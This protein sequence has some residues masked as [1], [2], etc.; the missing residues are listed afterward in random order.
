M[1]S[2]QVVRDHHPLKG[3]S[4]QVLGQMHCRGRLELL[5]VLPDGSKSLIPAA[6]TDHAPAE[7]EGTGAGPAPSGA[8]V[9]AWPGDL[10]EASVLVSAL[11][12]RTISDPEQA[13]RQFPSKEDHRA[14]RPAQSATRAVTPAAEPADSPA[15]APGTAGGPGPARPSHRQDDHRAPRG[16]R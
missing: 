1:T 11:L 8:G 3:Q 4:L 5:L 13:A 16:D 6:W 15:P 12:T 7:A 2:V 9:L 14:A 10:V